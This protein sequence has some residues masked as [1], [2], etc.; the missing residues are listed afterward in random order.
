MKENEEW[1]RET[2][3]YLK[4]FQS[5]HDLI[6]SFKAIWAQ[7]FILNCSNSMPFIYLLNNV[8]HTFIYTHMHG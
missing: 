7:I 8:L 1:G 6:K 5:N 4:I 2:S 3:L